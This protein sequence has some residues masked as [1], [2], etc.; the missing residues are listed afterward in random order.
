M[1]PMQ[2]WRERGCCQRDLNVI[3]QSG[4]SAR[5]AD[6][7]LARD[8]RAVSEAGGDV[9]REVGVDGGEDVDV[10]RDGADHGE[11]VNG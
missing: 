3:W 1:S 2:E 9:V 5:V 4:G 10:G 7:Y 6:G 8:G 11:Q